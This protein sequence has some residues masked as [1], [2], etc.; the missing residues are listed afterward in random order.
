MSESKDLAVREQAL[1]PRTS[2]AILTREA[3]KE[4]AEQRRLLGEYVATQMVDGTDFGT[5]PGTEKRG[6][7]G[8]PL[9]N[10]TLLKPGAEKLVD[11]FRCTPKFKLLERIED[12]D[13]GLYAYTFRVQLYQRDAEAVLAEGYGSANSREGRY[14]WRN[15]SRKCPSCG[16]ETIIKGKEEYGGGYLCFAKKGGCGA[17]FGDHDKAVVDQPIGKTE[18]DD[19]ATLANTILKMAKKR[20]LVDGAIALARVS[21]LFTQDVEDLGDALQGSAPPRE[22]AGAS[23][24][25]EA[26]PIGED[27]DTG[28]LFEE[29]KAAILGAR[30]AVDLDAAA[31]GVA[32]E[33]KAGRVTEAQR[34]M[35][36]SLYSQ[37]RAEV[38]AA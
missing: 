10:R 32:R 17:K 5:I 33:H 30:N 14:R 1:A 20:A 19:I 37:R 9:P 24:P 27:G 7:D 23:G 18:N 26:P 22:S 4:A 11:L 29:L 38:R 36:G 16:K 2:G 13:R 28:H 21:D 6:A 35:L 8:K 15:A 12:F 3:L 34:K 25:A 31:Q